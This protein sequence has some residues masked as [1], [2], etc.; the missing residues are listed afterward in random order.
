M[1]NTPSLDW[2][3]EIGEQSFDAQAFG[4]DDGDGVPAA[5][6]TMKGVP[7]AAA[8]LATYPGVDADVLESLRAGLGERAPS[9]EPL[10]LAHGP[11][12]LLWARHRLA[13]ALGDVAG[14]A[15]VEGRL[16][17]LAAGREPA[18]RG[19]CHGHAALLLVA[20]ESG[21]ADA[22]LRW[23]ARRAT[24]LP[25]AGEPV[26]LSV[27]HGAAGVV[28][29]LVHLAGVRSWSWPLELAADFWQR[30]AKHARDDGHLT[31][32]P[33]RQGLLGYFL[34]WSGVADSALLLAAAQDGDTPWVPAAFTSSRR[35]VTRGDR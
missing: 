21:V 7:G 12:G 5:T 33:V 3:E 20:A 26:D 25:P 24:S 16:A 19:W 4:A 22:D 31:G 8:L 29:A 32:D 23:H 2:V 34:G 28:Q 17:A 27:C 15:D 10:N 11:L 1:Q 35:R 6:D 30:V 13:R 18:P 14:L 9:P